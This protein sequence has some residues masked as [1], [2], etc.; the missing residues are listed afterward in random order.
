MAFCIWA[1]AQDATVTE[2]KKA[3]SATIKK[4]EKDTSQHVWKTRRPLQPEYQPG[5]IEQLVGRGDKFSFSLNA[6][7]NLYAFYKKGKTPGITA[8]IWPMASSTPHRW[9]TEKASDRIDLLSKYGYAIGK[10]GMH[11]PS[12]I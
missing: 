2:L 1:Q 4:D 3:S 12:S 7:L 5:F 9:V 8:L 6:Y 11:P 10:N